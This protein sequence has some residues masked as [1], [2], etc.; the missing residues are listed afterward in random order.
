MPIF[1]SFDLLLPK[2]E[3]IDKWPVVAC[4][5]FTSQPEYWQELKK[6]VGSAPSAL[7]CI[8]PEVEL[9]NC[10]EDRYDIIRSTMNGYLSAGVFNTYKNS[11]VYIERTLLNGSI[12]PGIVGV[13][14]LE[15][16]D[17]NADAVSAIRATEKTVVERIPPRMKVRRGAPIELSH[18]LLLCDD[19]K[20]GIIE[21]LSEKKARLQKLYE[22]ELMQG[23]GHICAWLVDG[24]DAVELQNSIEDYCRRKRAEYS[25]VAPMLFAVGDG[26]HSLATARE[27]YEE[28]KRA[29][30][31]AEILARARYAMVELENIMDESQKFEPIHRLIENCDVEDV[32]KFLGENCC[33]DEGYPISWTSNGRE[34]VIYLDKALGLLPIGILQT[35]LD[36]YL[37]NSNAEID[38]IHGEDTLRELAKKPDSIGFVLEAVAKDDFF[39]GIASDG[40]LPRKTFS[41]G[42]AQEKRY[43]IEAREII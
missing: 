22:L 5:Q 11:F 12:R 37:K 24:D 42:E 40:V 34:G 19:E 18:V 10:G 1:S 20:R 6:A 14:D 13:I 2:A 38:Y 35:A 26:N 28:L 8:L 7:N 3:Y 4:D 25:D 23:G 43:Y 41:M 29:G 31:G 16:Y 15:E 17:F 32:L 36:D 39:R 30:A 21:P 33:A 27:C 9:K